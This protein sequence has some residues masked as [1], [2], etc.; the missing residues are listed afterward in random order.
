MPT[1]SAADYRRA[2]VALVGGAF[3]GTD[4]WERIQE[5]QDKRRQKN[6][7]CPRPLVGTYRHSLQPNAGQRGAGH[8]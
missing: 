5:K 2:G 8:A 1:E 7:V 4:D 3:T 6:F